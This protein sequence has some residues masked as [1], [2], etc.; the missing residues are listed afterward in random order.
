VSGPTLRR[1]DEGSEVVELQRRLQ[2]IWVYR[3]PDDGDY[4]SRVE[5][6]VAEFQRWVSVQGD[7]SGV[8]G[9]ETRRALEERTS[10][11]GRRS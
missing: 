11:S 3:G 8:Y 4:S 2:E 9:P 7:P 1:G 5:Q 10:G 6:A